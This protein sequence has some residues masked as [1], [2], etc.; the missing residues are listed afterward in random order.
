MAVW[1]SR[2]RLGARRQ[3]SRLQLADRPRGL[4]PRR[5]DPRGQVINKSEPIPALN[6]AACDKIMER[7]DRV[8]FSAGSTPTAVARDK[9]QRAMQEDAAVFRTQEALES[10]CRRISA[11]WKGELQDIKVTDRSLIWNSDL[12]ETLELQNLMANAI[13]TVYGAEA[14]KESRGSHAREDYTSGRSPVATTST[15]ASTRWPG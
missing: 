4:R 13:T 2:L 15:G 12:V 14:R 9:M 8:R 7:F 3:P 10:G 11:I 6:K 5:R 1:R